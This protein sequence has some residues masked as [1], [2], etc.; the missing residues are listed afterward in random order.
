MPNI[1]NDLPN[2]L[3][4]NPSCKTTIKR[5]YEN[6]YPHGEHYLIVKLKDGKFTGGVRDNGK[7]MIIDEND[8]PVSYDPPHKASVFDLEK[9]IFDV[10]GILPKFDET[11]N[12]NYTLGP[13]DNYLKEGKLTGKFRLRYSG[14]IV[15]QDGF[16]IDMDASNYLENELSSKFKQKYNEPIEL[17]YVYGENGEFVRGSFIVVNSHESSFT[18]KDNGLLY[19]LLFYSKPRKN[20]TRDP[21]CFDLDTYKYAWGLFRWMYPE[22]PMRRPSFIYPRFA[23][24]EIVKIQNT[25]EMFEIRYVRIELEII[26]KTGQLSYLPEFLIELRDKI[27]V[28]DLNL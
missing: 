13:T 10:P 11:C 25:G 24:G 7:I 9:F 5:S 1:K 22:K 17:K 12:I 3:Y 2:R 15:N 26:T 8:K 27:S 20:G 18:K 14:Y 6:S 16:Q 21:Q 4:D 19:G 23:R 28:T